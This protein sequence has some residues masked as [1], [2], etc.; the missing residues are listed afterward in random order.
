MKKTKKVLLFVVALMIAIPTLFTSNVQAAKLYKK[1]AAKFRQVMNQYRKIK[2]YPYNMGLEEF[3]LYDLNRDGRKD[4][5][6]SPCYPSVASSDPFSTYIVMK[7]G[8]KYVSKKLKGDFVKAGSRAL[9]LEYSVKTYG[10]ESIVKGVGHLDRKT[11]FK[12][13][14]KGE[15][16][17]VAEY[18]HEIDNYIDAS[19][20]TSY[21]DGKGNNIGAVKYNEF[22]K[23][24][25]LRKLSFKKMTS[26]NVK[27][28]K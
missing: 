23:K 27:K 6:V 1:D 4:L 8:K 20:I 21:N 22:I 10:K 24:A 12:I 3:A 11:L 9:L 16:F 28:V 17:L 15:F 18:R 19:Y 25:K 5:I 7:V 13:S 14:K 2:K 26:A